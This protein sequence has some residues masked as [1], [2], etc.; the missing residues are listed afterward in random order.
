M[1]KQ[2]ICLI[3][4]SICLVNA[5]NEIAL[6]SFKSVNL[7]G[8]LYMG[9]NAASKLSLYF[10]GSQKLTFIV[11][12]TGDLN[13]PLS[14]STVMGSS[15]LTCG[16]T[17][18]YLG[19]FAGSTLTLS[20][21]TD[22]NAQ[23]IAGQKS[24]V[25]YVVAAY[26]NAPSECATIS[27]ASL[28]DVIATCVV[29]ISDLSPTETSIPQDFINGVEIDVSLP[30]GA[31][32]YIDTTQSGQN[33]YC[34]FFETQKYTDNQNFSGSAFFSYNSAYG[35]TTIT[36]TFRG[37]DRL[38]SH[39]LH[40]HT[41]GDL[42]NVNGL[43]VGGHWSVSGN[44]HA[45][46]STANRHL[47]DIGNVCTYLDLDAYYKFTTSYFTF[48]ENGLNPIGR[49]MALHRSRD[50]GT[51]T[52]FGDRIAT[53]VI[54]IVP[55]QGTPAYPVTIPSRLTFDPN[56]ICVKSSTTESS[57]TTTPTT[58]SASSS[59][60]GTYEPVS[61]ASLVQLSIFFYTIIVI[62]LIVLV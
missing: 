20:A 36:A 40:I 2:I 41:Y 46:P 38:S 55:N 9:Y 31:Q 45:L 33:A 49:G 15:P 58:S 47:G 19:N 11:H 25:G 54:G 12:N 27:Y 16:G 53:C 37:I 32:P 8:T 62:V 5:A 56:A 23:V 60:T 18:G 52:S 17:S 43:S 57:T 28:G 1:I 13:A 61:P 6:C 3:L 39:G 44:V 22:V 48:G 34:Q 26:P 21:N 30:N 10:T 42:T 51:T 50:D 29:G 14:S 4:L 35:T 59:T 7:T 24:I